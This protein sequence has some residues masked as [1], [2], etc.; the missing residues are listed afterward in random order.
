MCKNTHWGIVW[1]SHNWNE[2]NI[3]GG[4]VCGTSTNVA[5]HGFTRT[6]L[7]MC[8]R[9]NYGWWVK[10]ER[11]EKYAGFHLSFVS[12]NIVVCLYF[13]V[14][15]I[16]T[17]YIEGSGIGGVIWESSLVAWKARDLF[18]LD[19]TYSEVGLKVICGTFK[20]RWYIS[21]LSHVFLLPLG[22]GTGGT[23]ETEV[24]QRPP[25]LSQITR[26]FLWGSAKEWGTHTLH[27]SLCSVIIK[28]SVFHTPWTYLVFLY[29][30]SCPGIQIPGPF[31]VLCSLTPTG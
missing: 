5:Q 8:S 26:D 4:K 18:Y 11:L 25:S 10:K 1:M 19:Y 17:N 6:A 2:S 24:H 16:A 27:T 31:A 15:T 30:L 12:P 13:S 7:Q 22:Q 3:K 20:G 28:V 14:W 29:I 23:L 9:Y 21:H